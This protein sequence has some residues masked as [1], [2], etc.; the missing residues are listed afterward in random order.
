[1]S[2]SYTVGEGQEFNYPADTVS[3]QIIKNAGGRSKLTEDQKSLVKYKTATEG[4]DCSDMPKAVLELYVS[5]GWV[6]EKKDEPVVPVIPE[7][8]VAPVVEEKTNG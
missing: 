8:P 7:I 5:R 1:M 6:I 2:I 3:E 4:M